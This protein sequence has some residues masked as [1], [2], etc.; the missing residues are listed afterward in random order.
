MLLAIS[1]NRPSG[2]QRHPS[3]LLV[4]HKRALFTLASTPFSISALFIMRKLSKK[5]DIIHYHLPFPFCTLL[6]LFSARKKNNRHSVCTY[7]S[8]IIRQKVLFLLYSPFEHFFL[9]H[10]SIIFATSPQYVATSKTL[11]KHSDRVE[12]APIGID[13]EDKRGPPATPKSSTSIGEKNGQ[14]VLFLGQFRNYKGLNTLLD[15]AKLLPATRFLLA[16][17]GELQNRLQKKIESEKLQNV[18]IKSNVTE[19]QKIDLIKN[20]FTLVLPSNMRT[21]AFGVVLLEAGL[22]G[23]PLIT[24]EIGTGTSYVNISGTTGLAIPPNDP[25]ALAKALSFMQNDKDRARQMGN[26]A[27]N[28]VIQYFDEKKT[29][30]VYTMAYRSLMPVDGSF[31]S[32]MQR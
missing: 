15:A 4:V 17:G 32:S 25:E 6:Q 13:V 11:K 18:K 3:G 19:I 31:S 12:I 5:A 30:K 23:K 10:L 28:R 22:F 14:Y 26:E 27:R 2:L 20:C 8:D 21:E 9:N 29:C 16:G 24:C 1:P 7:H